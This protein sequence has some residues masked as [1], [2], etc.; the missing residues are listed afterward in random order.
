MA[1]GQRIKHIFG[2]PFVI[3]FREPMLMAITLYMSVSS[4]SP[5]DLE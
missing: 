5:S 1:F 2:R 3:L 4:V